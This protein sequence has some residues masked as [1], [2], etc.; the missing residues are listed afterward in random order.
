MFPLS[1]CFGEVGKGLVLILVQAFDGTHSEAIALWALLG[2]RFLNC[3]PVSL[4]VISLLNCFTS[5]RASVS[6]VCFWEL[7][8]FL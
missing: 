6:N 2:E 1:L 7:V 3:N 5:P 4:F 8:R